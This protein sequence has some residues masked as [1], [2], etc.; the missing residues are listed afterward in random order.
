M[1]L[2][3]RMERS[4][5]EFAIIPS[6][7]S[8]NLSEGG[9][10]MTCETYGAVWRPSLFLTSFK[11]GRGARASAP[12]DPLLIPTT[13]ADL[14]T[15]VSGTCPPPPN[16]TKFFRFYICF[17]QKMPVLEVGTPS[18]VGWRPPPPNGKSWIRPCTIFGSSWFS[19]LFP[20]VVLCPLGMQTRVNV[21]KSCCL[22]HFLE[23]CFTSS[24]VNKTFQNLQ[25]VDITGIHLLACSET[26]RLPPCYSLLFVYC[27]PSVANCSLFTILCC[28]L[29][30]G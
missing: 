3:D 15:K 1:D 23:T 20:L 17:H 29:L 21:N 14:H 7:G 6:S 30:K 24:S 8:R 4:K 13:V 12:P 22:A 25:N 9:G 27:Y 26:R 2:P 10:P 5:I 19:F 11:R 18:N 28:S 16:R